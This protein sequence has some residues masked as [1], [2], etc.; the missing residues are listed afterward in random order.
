VCSC[1]SVCF[2]RLK[3]AIFFTN[4]CMYTCMNVYMQRES[5]CVRAYIYTHTLSLYTCWCVFVYV[6]IQREGECERV[7]TCVYR[8][9]NRERNSSLYFSAH[10][11]SLSLSLHTLSISFFLSLCIEREIERE[12][13]EWIQREALSVY[14]ERV[15][16]C[17]YVCV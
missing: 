15:S 12:I 8:E 2:S 11:R 9:R 4:V 16:V 1:R 13:N 5:E 10:T 7:C 14:K 6:Y 17:M 3:L